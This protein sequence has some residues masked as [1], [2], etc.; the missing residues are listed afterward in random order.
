MVELNLPLP[1]PLAFDLMT[2]DPPFSGFTS[3]LEDQLP[4]RPVEGRLDGV[5]L[6][7]VAIEAQQRRM[8]HAKLIFDAFKETGALVLGPNFGQFLHDNQ[9]LI[10]SE[11]R[12]KFALAFWGRIYRC[13]GN[14]RCIRYL[15]WNGV[16]WIWE[17]D[18][19]EDGWNATRRA[20]V[21]VGP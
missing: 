9:R 3:K 4:G 19:F 6:L 2:P 16:R 21:L 1:L 14:G 7:L 8:V 18:W 12:G 10:P 13:S 15:V 20:V 5:N 17:F 11:L